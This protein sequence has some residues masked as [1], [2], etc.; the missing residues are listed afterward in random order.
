MGT[1]RDI[2]DSEAELEVDLLVRLHQ[3][4]VLGE[5]TPPEVG[6]LVVGLHGPE[7]EDETQE[8]RGDEELHC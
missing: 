1:L 2:E 4:V 6:L 7:D 8:G 5:E 3:L